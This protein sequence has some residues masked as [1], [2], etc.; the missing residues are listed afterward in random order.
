M[1]L[2]KVIS[3]QVICVVFSL[4]TFSAMADETEL[5]KSILNK[6]QQML[7]L[8]LGQGDKV[9]KELAVRA[10]KNAGDLKLEESEMKKILLKWDPA[11]KKLFAQLETKDQKLSK[12]KN[13]FETLLKKKVAEEDPQAIRIAEKGEF[14]NGSLSLSVRQMQ[15]L[16]SKWEK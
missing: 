5:R 11:S 9:A 4:C 12:I 14:N 2:K 1:M 16:I 15:E 8:K 3:F 13:N 10:Q 7:E 6:F